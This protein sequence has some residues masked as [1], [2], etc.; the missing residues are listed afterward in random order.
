MESVMNHTFAQV[1]SANISRSSFDRSHAHKTTIDADYIYPVLVDEVLPGD[2]LSVKGNFFARMATPINPIMDNLFID[3]FFFAIPMRILWT[4]W[5][6][7]LGAQ[8]DP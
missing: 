4:N 3:S 8:D 1:P 6:K 5:E 7:F 2:T